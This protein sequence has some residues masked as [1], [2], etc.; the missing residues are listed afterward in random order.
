MSHTDI[1]MKVESTRRVN[2]ARLVS[3]ALYS[4]GATGFMPRRIFYRLLYSAVV[5]V[6]AIYVWRRR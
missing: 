3:L 2:D 4:I 6:V 5:G 1:E